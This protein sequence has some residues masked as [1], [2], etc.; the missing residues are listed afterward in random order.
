MIIK[1]IKFHLKIVNK[2]CLLKNEFQYK[3][4]TIQ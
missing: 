3:G 2:S 1:M 4:L